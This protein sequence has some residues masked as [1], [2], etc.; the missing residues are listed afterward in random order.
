MSGVDRQ[1]GD[2]DKAYKTHSSS[3]DRSEQASLAMAVSLCSCSG[4]SR[5]ILFDVSGV[6]F[7]S[8]CTASCLA[9]TAPV[10]FISTGEADVVAGP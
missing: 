8:T 3:S 10:T 9:L 7:R 5:P 6:E 1:Q 2:L 4:S